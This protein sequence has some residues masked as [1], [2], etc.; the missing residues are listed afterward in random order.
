MLDPGIFDVA[1]A[2]TITA[3]A[4]W[5]VTRSW[6]HHVAAAASASVDVIVE[7]GE[8]L[9]AIREMIR[10]GA[11]PDEVRAVIDEASDVIDALRGLAP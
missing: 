11:T 2:A 5:A 8:L 3:V 9:V 7:S 10:D 4:T 6:Y 1:V